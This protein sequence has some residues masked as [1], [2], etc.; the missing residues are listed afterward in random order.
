MVD[1]N[2]IY[3]AATHVPTEA[4]TQ[5][6]LKDIR[7]RWPSPQ[8]PATSEPITLT[9]YLKVVDVPHI[10]ADPKKWYAKQ[11]KAFINALKVSP[12]GLELAKLIKHK[13]RFM[14]ASPHSDSCWAWIN[15]H[16]TVLGA[17]TRAFIDKVVNVSGV[18]CRILSAKPHSG[19]VLCSQCQRWGHHHQQC[20]AK[21]AHCSLC[22]GPH[23]AANH[24]SCVAASSVNV[25]QCV[26][27]TASGRPADRCQHAATDL[28]CLFWQH[29]FNRAWLRCQFKARNGTTC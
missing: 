17:R 27:C 23:Q 11:N 26:N 7:K 9:S 3:L 15:I 4:L 25:K 18:N 1:G 21:S 28:K 14:H 2:G 8:A 10:K 24:P 19:S 22:G 12:V 16:D 5:F 6:V 13:P 20:H 29:R